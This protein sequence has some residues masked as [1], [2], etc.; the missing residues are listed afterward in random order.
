MVLLSSRTPP[1]VYHAPAVPAGRRRN[2]GGT[3]ERAG[4]VRSGASSRPCPPERP[5]GAPGRGALPDRRG[6]DPTFGRPARRRSPRRGGGSGPGL[7]A[8]GEPRRAVRFPGRP[9]GGAAGYKHPVRRRGRGARKSGCFPGRTKSTCHFPIR[10]EAACPQEC[11]TAHTTRAECRVGPIVRVARAPAGPG[12]ESAAREDRAGALAY[13]P[14]AF[15]GPAVPA[16]RSGA[17]TLIRAVN[18]GPSGTAAA[19]GPAGEGAGPRRPAPPARRPPRNCTR[20]KQGLGGP[21]PDAG[22]RLDARGGPVPRVRAPHAARVWV[23]RGV[24]GGA[25]RDRRVL[26]QE[27]V[28]ARKYARVGGIRARGAKRMTPRDAAGPRFRP[29]RGGAPVRTRSAPASRRPSRRPTR[30]AP[31]SKPALACGPKPGAE[32]LSGPCAS[33]EYM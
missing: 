9:A 27:V 23:A 13:A 18:A 26:R 33:G 4:L 8:H 32:P 14:E 5:G 3:G 12:A 15:G 2:A 7:P 24:F 16:L 30:P 21:P 6:S 1:P 31:S 25:S 29:L 28:D 11:G 17:P 10:L 19:R 22:G 20:A